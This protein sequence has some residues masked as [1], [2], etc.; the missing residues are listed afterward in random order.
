MRMTVV[1]TRGGL[2]EAQHPV[3]VRIVGGGDAP[4]VGEDVASFWRSACKPLQLLTALDALGP[5]VVATLDD[6]ELAIGAAS[7]SGEPVHVA[8]VR[9]LL[10]RFGVDEGELRCGAHWPMHEASARAVAEAL[11]VHNNCSGKHT[12]MLAACVAQGWPME[13]RP[14]DHP[15]QVH[16][17]ARVEDWAGVRVGVAVDGCGVPT[18][19]LPL[20]AQA[21]TWARLAT[22][23]AGSLEARVRDAMGRVPELVSGTGRLDLVLTRAATEPLTCKVGAEGLFCVA[24]PA[25]GVGLAVKV[26]T[27]N[28]DALATAVRAVLDRFFPGVVAPVEWPSDVVLNVVGARVG[29]RTAVWS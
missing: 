2:F 3:S 21:R 24:L 14:L 8:Q 23:P 5:E 9:A 7:H 12:F 15:L 4:E 25:R 10:A 11:P 16:N 29:A 27:G 19:H 6:R 20:S 17:R 18:F 26:H 13:Y 28:G 1:Q 22:A